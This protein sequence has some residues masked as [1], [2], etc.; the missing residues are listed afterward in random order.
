MPGLI[1][2]KQKLRRVE[3]DIPGAE[4]GGI[5]SHLIEQ[6][7]AALLPVRPIAALLTQVKIARDDPAFAAPAKPI[8]PVHDEP[9]AGALPPTAAGASR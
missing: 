8:G 3:P 4:S 1:V 2:G 7:H 5:G 6:E 9:T